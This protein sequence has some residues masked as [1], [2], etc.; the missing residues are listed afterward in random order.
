MRKKKTNG[1]GP[2]N[3]DTRSRELDHLR[4]TPA[5]TLLRIQR[6]EEEGVEEAPPLSHLPTARELRAW[7][8]YRTR[9]AKLAETYLLRTNGL[10]L[11]TY[12]ED[13]ICTP[14]VFE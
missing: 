6:N 2:I 14:T 12:N 1:N 8:A 3:T 13:R 7:S 4:A 10:L 9:H 5:P 11:S